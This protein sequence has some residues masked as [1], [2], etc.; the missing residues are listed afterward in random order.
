MVVVV[1]IV[2][3]ALHPVFVEHVVSHAAI[4]PTR[5]HPTSQSSAVFVEHAVVCVS[6][7]DSA[8]MTFS[9]A[10]FLLL[11]KTSQAMANTI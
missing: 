7:K 9:L 10:R 6:F 3:V 8:G 4:P 2:P 5:V 11:M 1:S